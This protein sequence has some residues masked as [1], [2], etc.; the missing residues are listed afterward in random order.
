[1]SKNY[2]AGSETAKYRHLTVPY[3]Q[4]NGIDIGSGGDPVVPW[5]AS[6]DLPPKDY[7]HYHSNFDPLHCIQFGGDA[8]NLHW[9]RDGVFDFV[10]SSHLLE[11]FFEWEPVLREWIRVLKPGGNIVILV[12]D[13]TL[14]N[15]AIR[16]G[17][18]PNCAHTHESR[19]GE[20]SEYMSKLGV[21]PIIDQ[22][23]N[24]HEGDYSIL[25]VGR[26]I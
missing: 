3:C 15:D 16:R 11:D 13:K 12:P 17:Q 24:Q 7:A 8:K 19:V 6:V 14:W 20:L 22:L 21:Q 1:M 4:G 25:F 2:E 10:Y 5:A 9:F 26:K 18:P 23:T